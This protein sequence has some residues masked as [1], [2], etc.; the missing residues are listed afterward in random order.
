[1]GAPGVAVSGLA[2][3]GA[4]FIFLSGGREARVAASTPTPSATPVAP[5]ACGG[6]SIFSAGS[7]YGFFV[8]PPGVEWVEAHL[9]GAGG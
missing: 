8:V 7:G 5:A 2:S 4:V 1:V 6:T 3:A 9:F